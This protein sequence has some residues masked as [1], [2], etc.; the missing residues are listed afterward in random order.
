MMGGNIHVESALGAGSTFWFTSTFDKQEALPHED[1]RS[2]PM[3]M[4]T[5]VRALIIESSSINRG[6]LQA[7]M[8]NWGMSNRIAASPEQADRPAGAGGGAAARPTTSR[9]STSRCRAWTRSSSRARSA[10]AP[11]SPRCVWWC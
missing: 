2:S 8:S 3:G 4:L 7:Q 11:T 10:R 5:G 6:I 9:S 1:V